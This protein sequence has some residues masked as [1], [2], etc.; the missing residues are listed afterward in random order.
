MNS[1][2]KN[3]CVGQ[4]KPARGLELAGLQALVYPLPHWRARGKQK[5]WVGHGDAEPERCERSSGSSD[6]PSLGSPPTQLFLTEGGSRSQLRDS[7]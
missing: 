7:T 3:D 1:N 5:K 6:V 4:I 2:K